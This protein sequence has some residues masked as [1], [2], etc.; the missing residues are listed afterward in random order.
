[1]LLLPDAASDDEILAAVRTWVD[2]L[3]REDYAGAFA[4][5][6][7]DAYYGWTPQLIRE[8]IAGYGL[9]HDGKGPRH[10]VTSIESAGGTGSRGQVTW[11]ELPAGAS[12]LCARVGHVELDLPLDGSWSDLTATFELRRGESGLVLVLHEIRVL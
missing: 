3:A 5:T 10:R 1:M 8:V 4:L 6:D 12:P 9:P 11:Y 2:L 7:H